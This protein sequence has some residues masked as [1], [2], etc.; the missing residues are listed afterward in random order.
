MLAPLRDYFSP[1]D[2]GSS[3]LLCATKEYY[4]TWMSA[5]IDLDGPSSGETQWITLE[6]VNVEHLLDVFTTIDATSEDVWDACANFMKHLSWHKK[7]LT[8]L[9]PKIEGLPDDHHFKPTCLFRLSR[10]FGS[11]GNQVERKRLLVHALKLWRER[12][13]GLPVAVILMELSEIN[14]H[15]GLPE[16]GI[17]QAEEALGILERLGWTAGQAY[18]LIG[19]ASLLLSNEQFDAAEEAASRAINLLPEN[20]Q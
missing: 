8:I 13:S 7:R 19:L 3:S 20:G 16:E 12:G 15:M 10:L 2:P 6:D 1:M 5:D 18:C 11:I 4:F 9:K 17:Q 14:G